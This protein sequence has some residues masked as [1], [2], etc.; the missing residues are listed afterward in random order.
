MVYI[1]AV[2]LLF[3]LNLQFLIHYVVSS[4]LF[5]TFTIVFIEKILTNK[6]ILIYRYVEY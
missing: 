5:L 3:L 1:V 6:S 2:F 4:H